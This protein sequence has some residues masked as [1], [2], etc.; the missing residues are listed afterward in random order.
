MPFVITPSL[1]RAGQWMGAEHIGVPGVE[2]CGR[3][4]FREENGN[5]ANK[6]MAVS[7]QTAKGRDTWLEWMEGR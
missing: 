3:M 1:I 6:E 7:L 4:D 2:I 5:T